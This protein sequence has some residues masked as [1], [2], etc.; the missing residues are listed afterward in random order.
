MVQNP[1]EYNIVMFDIL[2]GQRIAL[3]FSLTRVNYSVQ[4]LSMPKI[5]SFVFSAI[6]MTIKFL[7][8]SFGSCSVMSY[9]Q[10]KQHQV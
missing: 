7:L 1:T 9:S 2:M 4:Q 10:P 5:T 3:I 8:G 6:R